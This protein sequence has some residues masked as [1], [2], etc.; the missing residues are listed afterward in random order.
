MGPVWNEISFPV[1]FQVLLFL[2]DK[3]QESVWT[4]FFPEEKSL[5]IY[6]TRTFQNE[7]SNSFG[8]NNF[9]GGEGFC[10][11]FESEKA[12]RQKKIKFALFRGGGQG[13]R[14]ENNPK[15]Y[16]SWETSWQYNF[17]S[18]NFIVEKFCC[19]GTGSYWVRRGSV[20]RI[21]SD[22]CQVAEGV[23]PLPV[24][25]SAGLCCWLFWRPCL[26]DD[27]RVC[28]LGKITTIGHPTR[29]ALQELRDGRKRAF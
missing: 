1:N 26:P 9:G 11:V 13:G 14:E 10:K 17:E 22:T 5:K 12:R 7:F 20:E 24:L 2:Q 23:W 27:G 16:F 28:P 29:V 6:W 8:A 21:P 4:F 25:S 18:A 15:R 3:L 19:H